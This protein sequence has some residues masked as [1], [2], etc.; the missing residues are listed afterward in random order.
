MGED[1]LDGRTQGLA[2][3]SGKVAFRPSKVSS[4]FPCSA[5][6][7][8]DGRVRFFLQ[9]PQEPCESSPPDGEFLLTNRSVYR[10]QFIDSEAFFFRIDNWVDAASLWSIPVNLTSLLGSIV[11]ETS[12]VNV[13]KPY[14]TVFAF[15]RKVSSMKAPFLQSLDV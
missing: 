11:E 8:E 4:P 3:A 2:E 1:R 7:P 15:N 9:S 10:A 14:P 13:S 5:H 6:L 12:A